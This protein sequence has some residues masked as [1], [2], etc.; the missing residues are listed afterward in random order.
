V[1]APGSSA[2]TPCPPGSYAPVAG[3][4]ACTPAAP[5][6]FVGTTGAIA[7]T[8]CSLGT[9]QDLMGQAS[10]NEAP[11]GFYVDVVAATEATP[12]PLG[13]YQPSAGATACLLAPVGTYV[14]VEGA[15]EATPCPA[16]TTT[17]GTG[18]TS[19]SDCVVVGGRA[20]KQAV[21]DAID[22]EIAVTT[23]SRDLHRLTSA[24][25]QLA[26]SLTPAWWVDNT[27]L[28]PAHGSRVFDA[29][30]NAVQALWPITK[31]AGS[32]VDPPTVQQWAEALVEIDRALAEQAM[33]DAAGGNAHRLALAEASLAKGDEAAAAGNWNVAIDHYR[34]AWQ[35][36]I[37]AGG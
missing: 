28:A 13:S 37:A 20:A 25:D 2:A 15:T 23:G 24:R 26:R 14:D 6:F 22:A 10:C 19:A 17:A 18:S 3:A 32:E 5:G 8:P 36:A 7:Q 29:E 34:V 30:R 11:P 4:S 9:Y 16:G 21:L 31:D 12:C 27:R 33:D 35:H 1:A